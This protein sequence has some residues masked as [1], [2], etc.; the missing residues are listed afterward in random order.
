MICGFGS[1]NS[2]QLLTQ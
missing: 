2:I 1:S